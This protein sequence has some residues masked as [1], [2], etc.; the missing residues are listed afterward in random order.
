MTRAARSYKYN[1]CGRVAWKL[2]KDAQTFLIKTLLAQ[3][4][5]SVVT[6]TSLQADLSKELGINLEASTIRRFLKS[7]GYRWLPRSQKRKYNS[8]QRQARVRFAKAALRLSIAQL[9]EKLS[10]SMDGV[11]LSMPPA[12]D[13]ERLNYCLGA[14][15]HMWRKRGEAA[16]PGL[17]GDNCYSKQVPLARAIP[18]WGGISEG[19]FAP[20]TFHEEKKLKTPDWVAAVRA[21]ALTDAIK[22]LSPVRRHGPWHVLCDGESFLHAAASK[23]AYARVNV[24]LW[25]VPRK[26]PDL[27]PV[28]MFW[29]WL[30]RRLRALDLQD[31][32]AKRRVLNK[33]SYKARVQAVC[34]SPAA[35]D[36]ASKCARRFRAT[37]KEVVAKKGAAARQ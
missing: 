35:Q 32:K 29:S 27:N 37:C 36:A 20:V 21:G 14:E 23:A 30:R 25:T 19:G 12:N 24:S 15:T 31:L 5:G 9:R 1:K 6:S 33:F 28:E 18:L 4:G 34:R 8:E 3:R 22:S 11:V 17:A 16:K 10:L 7:R 2:T 26:S 13:H